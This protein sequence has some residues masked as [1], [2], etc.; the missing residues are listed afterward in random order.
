GGS[1]AGSSSSGTTCGKSSSS[2]VRVVMSAPLVG[3]LSGVSSPPDP[4]GEEEGPDPVPSRSPPLS[5][6]RVGSLVWGL[7]GAGV[8]VGVGEGEGVS[9]G[10]GEGEG[11][12][13][14]GGAV[15]G[16]SGVAVVARASGE[17]K[18]SGL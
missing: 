5:S 9:V 3:G 17:R 2:R 18:C 6:F 1:S 12:S 16:A 4:L 8:S 11:V 15:S 14:G 13:E 10:V 7:V